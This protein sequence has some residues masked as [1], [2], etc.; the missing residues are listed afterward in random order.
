VDGAED[1]AIGTEEGGQGFLFSSLLF[2][3]S[4]FLFSVTGAFQLE[5]YSLFCLY[6]KPLLTFLETK[7]GIPFSPHSIFFV[8]M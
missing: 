7:E 6:S 3:L 4:F 1:D 8:L 2:F 5:I